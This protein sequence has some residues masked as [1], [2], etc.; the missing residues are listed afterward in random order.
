MIFLILVLELELFLISDTEIKK[1]N[2]QYRNKNST[3]DVISLSLFSDFRIEWGKIIYPYKPWR[4]IYFR[5]NCQEA[6]SAEW[7]QS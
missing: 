1:I 7:Y 2:N 3:T 4:Y 5:G 6:G